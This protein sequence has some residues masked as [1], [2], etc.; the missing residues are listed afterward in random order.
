MKKTPLAK[1]YDLIEE[2]CFGDLLKR[3]TELLEEERQNLIEAYEIGSQEADDWHSNPRGGTKTAEQ[4]FNENYQ[5]RHEKRL[6]K[7]AVERFTFQADTRDDYIN[8]QMRKAYIEGA[9]MVVEAYAQQQ[10]KSDVAEVVK[11]EC[12]TCNGKKVRR[13]FDG[14]IVICLD[15]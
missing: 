11:S 7:K 6:R 14:S 5:Q 8:S 10:V 1:A 13:E 4:Y 15:C 9:L 2:G 12:K 3:K